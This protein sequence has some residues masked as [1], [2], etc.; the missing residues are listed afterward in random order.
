VDIG[1]GTRVGCIAANALRKSVSSTCIQLIDCLQT[2]GCI[3]TKGCY[4]A[5]MGK[6]DPAPT[7]AAGLIRTARDRA[8]MTQS[9]LAEAA[10][11]TQQA[12][13]AY[14]TGRKEPTIPTVQRILAAAGFE[15]R[16]RLERID[17]HDES[18][19]AFLRTL[20]PAQQT[21]IEEARRIRASE[22]RLRRI[23]GK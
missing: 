7:L 4:A 10:G 21:V 14:E 15:M 17:Y 12:V 22:A 18:L 20:P 6:Y 3:H 1:V 2:K 13:S 11:L 8:G 5:H 16:I 23:R 19:E 9:G